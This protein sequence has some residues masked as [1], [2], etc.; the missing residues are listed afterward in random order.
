MGTKYEEKSELYQISNRCGPTLQLRLC[1]AV[2]EKED[3]A[4]RRCA[5]P[6]LPQA[7]ASYLMSVTLPPL[8]V[9]FMSW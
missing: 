9:T 3:G 6:H 5:M 7:T 8:K 2:C 4:W 1:L